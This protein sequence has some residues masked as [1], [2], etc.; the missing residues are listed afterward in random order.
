MGVRAEKCRRS[1]WEFL[2]HGWHVLEPGTELEEWWHLKAICDHV[3]WILE[4]WLA[5]RRK[6]P[7]GEDVPRKGL[8]NAPP[9]VIKS[10][11]LSVYAP[12]W[13]WLHAPEWRVIVL[14]VNPRVTVRDGDYSR[15][16]IQSAWY[17]TWFKPKWSIRLDKDG[18]TSYANTAGGSRDSMPW[19]SRIVGQRAD[20]E[21]IDD[22]NDPDEAHSDQKRHAVNG[23][24]DRSHSNRVNDERTSLQ[25]AIQ[26]RV[27]FDDWSNHFIKQIGLDDL[28]LLRLP[29]LFVPE[30]RC[31]TRL[32]C[33]DEGRYDRAGKVIGWCDP[34]T[35]P[36]EVLHP[37]RFPPKVIAQELRKGS[38][39]FA[40]QHQQSPDDTT[41]SI[42]QRRNW[43]WYKP[44]GV[45]ATG[46]KRPE[47]CR[48]EDELP[49]IPLPD[50]LDW[51]AMSIDCS[52]KKTEDGSRVSLQ[53]WA[54]KGS[55]RFLLAN[56]TRH[57]GFWDTV[58]A[59]RELRA[60]Y[61]QCY[62]IYV[63][64]K[65]NGPAVI[66][67][68]KRTLTG[69]KEVN[70]QGGKE[71]RAYACQGSHESGD[72]YLPEGAEFLEGEVDFIGEVSRF[73]N[74]DKDDQVDSMTQLL[75]EMQISHDMARALMLAEA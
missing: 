69:V 35:V 25:L 65:A 9:G 64:D 36:E 55:K 60:K 27:H 50:K 37:I 10:R 61:T 8:I 44:D 46:L 23:K 73:P 34:R 13:M 51:T 6:E 39:R 57:M 24:W 14:S 40:A 3:Q 15:T 29:T 7:W 71:A 19:F 74:G 11:I 63:E 48:Q 1:L 17:Q 21:I 43:R 30:R 2:R 49:S 4:G 28:M 62:R 33:N 56:L 72:I 52:F 59:A 38:F 20:A 16:L 47:G 31:M 22:P 58:K 54:G 12:A 41:G 32:P 67:E 70:P 45:A 75:I 68:L 18:S 5:R 66:E 42:F 26:Q 53:V